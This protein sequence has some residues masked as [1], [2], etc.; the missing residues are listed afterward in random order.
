M[1]RIQVNPY[2]PS[3]WPDLWAL[4]FTQLAEHG[5]VF[6]NPTVPAIDEPSAVGDPEY[7]YHHIHEIYLCGKGNF[8]LAYLD[9]TPIGHIGAQDINGQIELRRMF[10]AGSYRRQGAGSALVKALIQH[11]ANHHV[12]LI[13]LWTQSHGVGERLYARFGFE[14]VPALAPAFADVVAL[15]HFEPDAD[16]VRMRL[17][18]TRA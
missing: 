5:I 2:A 10:V 14:V 15:T 18:L 7:D 9:E 17:C 3:R 1:S 16:E 4:R 8:W 13:E 11:A 6:D 12:S